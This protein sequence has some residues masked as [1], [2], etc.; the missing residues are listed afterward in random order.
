MRTLFSYQKIREKGLIDPM[1]YY[2]GDQNI[3]KVF[4]FDEKMRLILNDLRSQYI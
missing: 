3:P 4:F 1:S 2:K